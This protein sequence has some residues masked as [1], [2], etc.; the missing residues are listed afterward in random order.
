MI[1]ETFRYLSILMISSQN[2]TRRKHVP[3]GRNASL[4]LGLFLGVNLVLQCFTGFEGGS[5]GG[6][7]LD[8][9][10]CPRIAGGTGGA[11]F[12]IKGA[13]ADQLN[14]F[15]FCQRTADGVNLCVESLFGI[16]FGDLGFV[17]QCID[18]FTFVHRLFLLVFM[19]SH[20]RI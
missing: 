19:R 10:T 3:A 14:L 9:C 6:L 2:K 1:L 17:G 11:L 7:D 8:F 12:D 16:L 18:Q 15:A 13:E 5:L 20:K 4:F